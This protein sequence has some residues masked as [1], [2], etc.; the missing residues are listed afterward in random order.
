MIR[1]TDLEREV[2]AEM[3]AGDEPP[4]AIL[5]SQ[6]DNSS[7]IRREMTGS[8]FFL[9]FQQPETQQR[10]ACREPFS[11]GDVVANIVG[12]ERGAGFVLH[13]SGGSIEYLEGFSYEEPWPD[14]VTGFSLHRDEGLARRKRAALQRMS[15]ADSSRQ[16]A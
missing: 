5:R 2:M 11:F 6:F 4:L 16:V 12:L 10:L 15:R 3:L 13:G 1:L 9:Y 14:Q 8:G 7:A